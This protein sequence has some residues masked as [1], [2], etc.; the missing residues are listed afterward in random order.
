MPLELHGGAAF[1]GVH[2]EGD[3]VKP[4]AQGYMRTVEHG[5]MSRCELCLAGFLAI[6][7]LTHQKSALLSLYEQGTKDATASNHLLRRPR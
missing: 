3:S 1:L 6:I 5:S 4:D 7:S 2:D